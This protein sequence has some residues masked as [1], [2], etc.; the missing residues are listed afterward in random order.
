[1]VTYIEH[2]PDNVLHLVFGQNYSSPVQQQP[3]PILVQGDSCISSPFSEINAKILGSY[4]IDGVCIPNRLLCDAASISYDVACILAVSQDNNKRLGYVIEYVDGF[5]FASHENGMYRFGDLQHNIK[6]IYDVPFP[7]DSLI[8]KLL[9]HCDNEDVRSMLDTVASIPS[10]CTRIVELVGT[11]DQS[12]TEKIFQAF[13]GSNNDRLRETAYLRQDYHEC[14]RIYPRIMDRIMALTNY[15]RNGFIRPFHSIFSAI[16]IVDSFEGNPYPNVPLCV[17]VK[18]KDVNG[19]LRCRYICSGKKRDIDTDNLHYIGR[20]KS[21]DMQK[22]QQTLIDAQANNNTGDYTQTLRRIMDLVDPVVLT[23]YMGTIYQSESPSY[24]DMVE[25]EL[26]C[27]DVISDTFGT[28]SP[29]RNALKKS[30]KTLHD[31]DALLD[32]IIN[33]E[34]PRVFKKSARK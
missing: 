32:N 11:A 13:R 14:R 31:I 4:S 27:F 1:M 2:I 7:K 17:S 3:N 20:A 34:M 8:E 33:E 25:H 28:D 6:A 21:S 12:D 19:C 18:Y 23:G 29:L 16:A 9:H 5:K 22:I 10:V 24:S 15:S 30:S 26:S